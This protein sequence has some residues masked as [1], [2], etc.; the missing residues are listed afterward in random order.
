MAMQAKAEYRAGC[1][2]QLSD[3]LLPWYRVAISSYSIV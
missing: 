3:A 2:G 1:S